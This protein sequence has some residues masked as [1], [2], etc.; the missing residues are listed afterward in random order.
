MKRTATAL[1]ASLIASASVLAQPADEAAQLREAMRLLQERISHLEKE[2]ARMPAAPVVQGDMP[3]SWKIPGTQTS[4]SISGQVAATA[5]VSSRGGAA[6]S[7]TDVN[8]IVS[9]I[10]LNGTPGVRTNYVKLTAQ[11]SILRVR[12]LTPTPY[13]PLTSLIEGDFHGTGGTELG[14]NG[15]GFRVRHAWATLGNFSFGQYW[16]NAAN[17][18]AYPETIYQGAD[19]GSFNGVR[20]TGFRYTQPLGGVNFWSVSAENPESVVVLNSTNNGATTVPDNDKMADLTGKIH[21]GL[22]S[23]QYEVAGVARKISS[24]PGAT[25]QSKWGYGISVSGFLPIGAKDKVIFVLNTG[26]NSGRQH[27]VHDA[28][29]TATGLEGVNTFAG[30]ISYRHFWS[31]SLRSSIT[32]SWLNMDNPSGV[33][34]GTAAGLNKSFRTAFVNLI[35]AATPQLEFGAELLRATREVE[36]GS[37]GAL[38]RLHFISKYSF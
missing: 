2:A 9:A 33:S 8:L 25:E 17:L 21:F 34:V 12:T 4:L 11:E 5:I 18:T 35:W 6:T 10:P 16:S 24:A 37:K 36:N 23:G 20:Q 1:A 7:P 15:H 38:S 30:L 31:E 3:R 13:G 28:V 26:K 19:I 27:L 14:T 32:Y 22:G 29:L